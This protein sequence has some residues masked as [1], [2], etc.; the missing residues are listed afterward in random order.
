MGFNIAIETGNKF[1]KYPI[2]KVYLLGSNPEI[3]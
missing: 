3:K 1:K 2:I